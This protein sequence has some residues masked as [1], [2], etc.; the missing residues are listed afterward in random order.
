MARSRAML[1]L[2]RHYGW[3]VLIGPDRNPTRR[4]A[5]ATP[6]PIRDVDAIRDEIDGAGLAGV[7][8]ELCNLESAAVQRQHPVTL[9]VR[10]PRF[11]QQ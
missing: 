8:P 10:A 6:T 5:S 11:I 2:R 9:V 3:A 4:M 7:N 1:S